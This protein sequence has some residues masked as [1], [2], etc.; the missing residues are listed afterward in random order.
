MLG[1]FWFLFVSSLILRI[2]AIALAC[3]ELN[4]NTSVKGTLITVLWLLPEASVVGLPPSRPTFITVPLS[5]LV[6]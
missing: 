2:A 3:C 1:R 4:G 6:Q 5:K